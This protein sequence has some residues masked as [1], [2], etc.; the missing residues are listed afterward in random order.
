MFKINWAPALHDM[1]ALPRDVRKRIISK[2]KSILRKPLIYVELLKGYPL[3]KLRVGN[4]RL[5]LDIKD[6]ELVV[7]LV[8][9]RSKVYKKLKRK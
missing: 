8:A 3:F 2:A 1:R 9:H 4:Y 7:V 5:I 6:D